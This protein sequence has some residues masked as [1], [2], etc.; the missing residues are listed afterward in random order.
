MKALPTASR[1]S[2]WI[3]ITRQLLRIQAG[4]Y[5]MLRQFPA[6]LKA[7]RSRLDIAPNDPEVE[8]VRRPA[9]IRLRVT[10]KKPLNCYWSKRTDS[11]GYCLH[12]VR[13]PN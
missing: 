2:S 12:S 10:C 3:H 1:G 9:F 4:T 8:G 11:F 6:A 13:S 7:P 5:A